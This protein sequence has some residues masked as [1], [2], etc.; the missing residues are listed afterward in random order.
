MAAA[1]VEGSAGV[2]ADEQRE[3][4]LE[5]RRALTERHA[6]AAADVARLAAAIAETCVQVAARREAG[7]ALLPQ[8]ADELLQKA[9]D[10]RAFAE[11][12][13]RQAARW[14]R[15]AADVHP[16]GR[17]VPGQPPSRTT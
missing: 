1:Q 11:H 6:R 5:R 15:L 10:A 13:R 9:R 3:N 17:W 16:A 14:A 8:H 2:V 7:A 4:W 12:E